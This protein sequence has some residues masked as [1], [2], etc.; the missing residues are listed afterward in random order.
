MSLDLERRQPAFLEMGFRPFFLC[1]AVFSVITMGLWAGVLFLQWRPGPSGLAPAA[2]HAH[3]MIYGYAMAVI[4]GFLLTAVRN[5]TGIQTLHG[6]GLAGLAALWVVVRLLWV[7]GAEAPLVLMAVMDNLFILLLL[8]S[9]SVPVFRARNWPQMGIPSKI[10]LLLFSNVLFYLGVFQVVPEGV[11]WGI[12]SGLYLVIGLILMIGRRVI[13]FFI[14]KGAAVEVKNWR[15][16]DAASVILFIAFWF[17]ASFTVM[18]M[19]SAVLAIIL[20]LILGVRMWGWH[21]LG[22]WKKP[23]LWILYLAHG[24]IMVGFLL[25]AL[26]SS[27]GAAPY[28]A[29]HAFAAGGIGLMTMGMMAR[30]ALAHTGRNIHVLPPL[31]PLVFS[32]IVLAAIIRVVFPLLAPGYGGIWIAGSQLLWVSAFTMFA[33]VY[34][35]MLVSP[36]IQGKQ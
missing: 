5:W 25:F 29:I 33:W 34:F 31:L 2:W 14:S 16:V 22:I 3:E 4:A 28:L 6:Y 27:L 11:E 12:Y 20:F 32:L 26:A 19:V 36:R 30:V 13:P 1:A 21:T 7:S 24:F 15:W 23:L 17:F 10:L 9:L 8:I 18:F 35:P